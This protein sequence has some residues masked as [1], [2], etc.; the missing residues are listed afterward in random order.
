MQKLHISDL[1]LVISV[2]EKEAEVGPGLENTL[3][4]SNNDSPA[5]G[6]K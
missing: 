6:T 5:K 1:H 2:K 4:Y 3:F